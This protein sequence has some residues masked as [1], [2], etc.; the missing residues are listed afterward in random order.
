MQDPETLIANQWVRMGIVLALALLIYLLLTWVGSRFVGR[1]ERRAP[2]AGPRAATL[3]LMVRRVITVVLVVFG[4]LMVFD[5]WGFSL[6][7]FLAI[8][9][10]FGAAIGFGAQDLVKDV[11]AGF[12]IL[13]ENQY[14]IGDTVTIADT[15]GTVEDIQF[16]ITVLRDFEGN[17]HFVPNGQITV[18]SNFTNLYAQPV[19]DVGIGYGADVD[20]AM[21]VMLDELRKL[22]SDPDWKD[23]ITE[24]P[25]MLGVQELAESAVIVRARLTTR[26]DERWSVR[27]EALL[28]I[29]KR[30]DAEGIE[31]PFPHLTIFQP[32]S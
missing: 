21:G 15:S 11:L 5:I 30:L 14:R 10:V 19:L 7:P 13:A 18:T 26:A 17:V 28:R 2:E 25:E 3:W 24:E 8:G 20:H 9:T 1:V 6:T 22:A 29:K 23:R 16:R 32:N 12:F 31:I 27:R 4:L